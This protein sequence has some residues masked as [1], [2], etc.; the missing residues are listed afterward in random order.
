MRKR[1]FTLLI[2]ALVVVGFD[3]LTK[4]W[5]SQTLVGEPVQRF[6]ADMFRLGYV[7]N[8]GVFLG[9]G[10]SLPDWIRFALFVVLVGLGLVAAS[11]Y[12][13]TKQ[14]LRSVQIVSLGMILSGGFSNLVDRL[15]H[16]GV[17]VDFMNVGIGGLRTG[18]FNIADMA[19]T[20]GVILLVLS[21]VPKERPK[22]SIPA[23]PADPL[24]EESGRNP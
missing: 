16:D 17:V 19:V 6:L 15:L 13:L 12:T 18:V 20:A 14:G 10:N 23:N 11:I 22:A 4:A 1:I 7:E 5:A 8:S 9:L 3:R 2:I 24:E 21:G